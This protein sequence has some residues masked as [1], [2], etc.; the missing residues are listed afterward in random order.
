MIKDDKGIAHKMTKEGSLGL[1]ALG[2]VGIR[3]WR[4]F[5]KEQQDLD[6]KA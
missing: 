5:K 6:E 2:D 1:L 4:Q 3:L